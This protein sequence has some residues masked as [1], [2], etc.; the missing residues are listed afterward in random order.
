VTPLTDGHRERGLLDRLVDAVRAGESKVLV[1]RGEPGVGKTVLLDYLTRRAQGCHLLRAGGVQSEMEL[2]FAGLH[3]LCAPLLV[4]MDQLPVPQRDAL[5]IAFGL[6]AGPPPDRFLVSLAVLSLLSEV[7][8]ERPHLLY[9][10]WLRQQNRRA[11]AREQLRIAHDMLTA[12]GA[13]AFADARQARRG[14][15]DQPGDRRP[16]VPVRPD[17]RMAPAQGVRQARHQL[18]PGPA[19]GSGRP[20]TGGLSLDHPALIWA[21]SALS[22]AT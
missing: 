13:E 20:R 17:G 15:A 2:A 4:R 16:A 6:S 5:R 18:A 9:G 22:A 11:E 19:P 3:Q 8:G 12:I 1:L 14:R 7:A 21:R 10:E